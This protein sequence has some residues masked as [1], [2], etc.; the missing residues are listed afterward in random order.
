MRQN[1]GYSGT[2][3]V[4]NVAPNMQPIDYIDDLQTAERHLDDVEK[5]LSRVRAKVAR[6]R[7]DNEQRQERLARQADIQRRLP[8]RIHELMRKGHH[9]PFHQAAKEFGTFWQHAQKT[10]QAHCHERGFTDRLA[11]VAACTRRGLNAED[12]ATKWKTVSG[13]EVTKRTIERDVNKIKT[14]ALRP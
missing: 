6:I 3:F 9:E 11:F 1:Q 2:P 10:F 14:G 13:K 4:P 12:T 7:F 8:P 5:Y